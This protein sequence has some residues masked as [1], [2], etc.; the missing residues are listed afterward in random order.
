MAVVDVISCA[1]VLG[2]NVI[3]CRISEAAFLQKDQPRSN[4]R[5]LM[6]VVLLNNS[7]LQSIIEPYS[8]VSHRKVGCHENRIP[9]N[10]IGRDKQLKK[11]S[12]C[13][14]GKIW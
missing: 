12:Q 8:A 13:N 4:L 3:D 9:F 2:S 11:R 14:M 10:C 6:K 7:E 1:R 5:L